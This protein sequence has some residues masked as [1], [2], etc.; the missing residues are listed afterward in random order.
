MGGH[1]G[2]DF[3]LMDAFVQA[4]RTGDHS[5]VTTSAADA[6]ESHLLVF[7]AEA[8]RKSRTVVQRRGAKHTQ[9]AS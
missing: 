5:L 4:I 7:D 2:S 9:P 8:A 3:Y 6:L 1:G